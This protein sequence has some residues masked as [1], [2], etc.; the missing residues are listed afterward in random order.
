MSAQ[1]APLARYQATRSAQL[2]RRVADAIRDLDR[3]GQSINL[4]AVAAA[5]DVDRAFIYDHPD[6]RETIEK[7][8]SSGSPHRPA[9][10][11]AEQASLASL[12]A[13]LEV[14]HT[15][16]TRLRAE[17]SE[18]RAALETRLGEQWNSHPQP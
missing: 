4:S 16:L 12:R 10:P 7:L 11:S 17:N 15:E 8:R 3:A 9:R 2:R 1:P 13:R 5:A 14:A 18:L 6:L